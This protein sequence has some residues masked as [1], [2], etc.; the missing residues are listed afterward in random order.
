MPVLHLM[1]VAIGLDFSDWMQLIIPFT[2]LLSESLFPSS[3]GLMSTFILVTS[4][5]CVSLLLSSKC[6][7][8]LLTIIRC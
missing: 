5:T 3:L 1:H 8:T 4:M 2:S 6:P 7:A